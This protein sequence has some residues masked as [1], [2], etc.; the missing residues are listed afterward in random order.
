V[1]KLSLDR[2]RRM[3]C[4]VRYLSAADV[5]AMSVFDHRFIFELLSDERAVHQPGRLLLLTQMV[6]DPL[7]MFQPQVIRTA[8]AD[9]KDRERWDLQEED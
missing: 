5:G 2:E 3:R 7:R 4:R 6:D 1:A 8:Q 9:R